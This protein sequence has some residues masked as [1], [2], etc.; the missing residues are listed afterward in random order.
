[1]V[2]NPMHRRE[3]SP[4]NGMGLKLFGEATMG[5]V[6]FGD[7]HHPAGADIQAMYDSWA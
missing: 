6:V 3:V 7:H 4:V 1:M 5:E 2:G